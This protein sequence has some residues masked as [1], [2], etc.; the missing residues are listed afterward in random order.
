MHQEVAAFGG[1]DQAT[2]CGLPFRKIL[3]SLRQLHDVGGGILEGND[4]ATAGKRN[5]IVEGAFPVRLWPDGQRR[6]PSV[7]WAV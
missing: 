1:A 5:R 4:L 3:L 2:N 7:A 6:I